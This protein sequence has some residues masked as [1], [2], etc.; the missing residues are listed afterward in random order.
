MSQLSDLYS[1]HRKS[2]GFEGQRMIVLP[3]K[4]VSHLKIHPLL[5]ALF[6]THIGYFPRAKFHYRERA[7][8]IGEYILI[9]CVEGKGW[10]EIEEKRFDV[11]AND[12]FILPAG[13]PHRYSADKEAPWSI[14]WTHFDGHHAPSFFNS[15]NFNGSAVHQHISP[16]EERL[17]I[18]EDIFNTLEKGYSIDNM[19]YAS[20]SLWRFLG[21]FCFPTAHKSDN[22]NGTNA[23]TTSINYMKSNIQKNLT[24][25][26]LAKQAHYSVSHYSSIFKESTGYSPINYFIFLKIQMACQFLDLT[27]LNVKE[28][29]QNVGYQD[30]H[31]FSRI[32]H[33]IMGV[34]PTEYRKEKKG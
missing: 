14:Y 33:K 5:N 21:S 2:E 8:G 18:F 10:F 7:N 32:F 34:S 4:I 23:I 25:K 13:I 26:Q 17:S 12:F 24:L 15:F 19:G 20:T 29:A 31:Y 16:I 3:Q 11:K 6:T 27:S 30:P 28:I 1:R 22:S 9:Y